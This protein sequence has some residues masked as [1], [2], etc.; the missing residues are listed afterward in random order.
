MALSGRNQRWVARLA[1]RTVVPVAPRKPRIAGR[2]R[3]EQQETA[4]IPG[5][6]R[7]GEA[8]AGAQAG[9]G[10]GLA[11]DGQLQRRGDAEGEADRGD[12]D[13]AP[14]VEVPVEA[15]QRRPGDDLA[16]PA[17]EDRAAERRDQAEGE[18]EGVA[19]DESCRR[20]GTAHSSSA[21]R[22]EI[23]PFP[24]TLAG[25]WPSSLQISAVIASV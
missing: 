1:S 18:V 8:G 7:E 6:R 16:R 3:G 12:R 15:P 2:M 23:D 13:E 17:E 14:G 5:E 22:V 11:D 24:Q 19:E 10:A 4:A 20:P 25:C 21:S 9:G